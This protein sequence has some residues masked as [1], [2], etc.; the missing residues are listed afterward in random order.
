MN[1]NAFPSPREAATFSLLL[2]TLAIWPPTT[3]QSDNPA[4]DDLARLSGTWEVISGEE[5]GQELDPARLDRQR[6]VFNGRKYKVLV[7]ERVVEEGTCQ[8]DPTRSPRQIDLNIQVGD[9]AG[10]S[11]LGLYRLGPQMLTL[12]FNRA[13]DVARPKQFETEADTTQFTL[14]LK[15]LP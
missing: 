5:A 14:R 4:T 12:S 1:A 13:G 3:Q 10:K 2:L 9:E 8:L 6:L 15:R 7:G 11:Q